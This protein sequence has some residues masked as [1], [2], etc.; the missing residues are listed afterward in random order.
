MWDATIT[1][2]N[3]Y[4]SPWRISMPLTAEPT[5]EMFEYACHE[6]NY[7][8]P[9]ALSGRAFSSARSRGRNGGPGPTDRAEAGPALRQERRARLDRPRRG[10]ARGERRAA[11]G[12]RCTPPEHRRF[13][14]RLYASGWTISILTPSGPVTNEISMS[15]PRGLVKGRGSMS[16]S[17]PLP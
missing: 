16:K 12:R 2:P 11:F 10:R 15:S 6:G 13:F 1:D 9:N 4:T 8:V 17:T 14:R 3:V 5:Y 7:A